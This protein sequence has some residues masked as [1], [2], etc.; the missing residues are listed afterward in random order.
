MGIPSTDKDKEDQLSSV[1]FS[2]VPTSSSLAKPGFSHFKGLQNTLK[3]ETKQSLKNLGG[4][5][6][7]SP[8]QSL[9]EEVS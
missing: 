3:V 9:K 7:L 5:E 4:Q 8:I 2:P 6:Q 1:T